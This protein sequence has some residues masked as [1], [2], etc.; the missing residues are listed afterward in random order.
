MKLNAPST[1]TDAELVETTGRLARS[2]REATV[3][4]IAHLAELY[5]RRLH[6]RAGYDSLFTYCMAALGLSE[7]AAYDRMKAAKV[8]RRFPVVLALLDEGRINLTTVRLVAPHLT[9]ANHRELLDAVTGLRKRQVQEVLARRF[10]QPD[11]KSAVRKLPAVASAPPGVANVTGGPY[12]AASSGAL[13][14]TPGPEA[15]EA[16]PTTTA[17]VGLSPVLPPMRPTADAVTPLAAD[18]YKITFT[19]SAAICAKL[20]MARD[21]LRHAVPGGDPAAIFERALDALVEDLVRLKFAV[22]ARPAISRG[23]S[24][25]SRHVP[26]EV[27]R[28]AYVRDRGSCAYVSPD[29]R[30]CGA[31]GFLEFH[32]VDP[33]GAR[34]K[35]TVDNIAL[36]CRAHNRYEA[37]VFYGPGRE[38]GGIPRMSMAVV[39]SPEDGPASIVV[40][41]QERVPANTLSFR[42]ER[43]GCARESGRGRRESGGGVEAARSGPGA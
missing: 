18:R 26:V 15:R 10:P 38:Y 43:P 21:L 14:A 39:P 7:S 3:V 2:E 41:G 40:R 23:Q 30:R 34:G 1:L 12:P 33:Y 13:P 32:H 9:P 28:A 29:G 16:E 25:D 4:L 35:A 22:T 37:E 27:K 20:E 31:R 19:A 17:R 6:E 5:G 42:N 8:A 11:V 24:G 36:R